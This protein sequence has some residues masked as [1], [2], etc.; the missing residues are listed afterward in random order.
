MRNQLEKTAYKAIE[1]VIQLENRL[2]KEW[3][4]KDFDEYI[5][6]VAAED[7]AIEQYDTFACLN[8]HLYDAF[9][10][11][12][13]RSGEIR[14]PETAAWLL[15]ETLNEMATCSDARIPP[16]STSSATISLSCLP[17]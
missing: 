16:F 2:L 6:A 4:D 9:E 7:K 14:D 1:R 8:D 10:L 17:F 15:D 12:D 3:S 13:W 5:S 11:V